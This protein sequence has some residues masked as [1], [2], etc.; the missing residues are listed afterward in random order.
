MVVFLSTIAEYIALTL[1]I[2]KKTWMRLLLTEQ[3]VLQYNQQHAQIKASESNSIVKVITSLTI[4]K[5]VIVEEIQT[6]VDYN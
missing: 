5:K 1:V 6:S 4:E 3:E 2:K